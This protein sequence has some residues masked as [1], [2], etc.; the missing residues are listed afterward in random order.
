MACDWSCNGNWLASG[1]RDQLV[2]M[3]DIRVMKEFATFHGHNNQVG[4][5]WFVVCGRFL[6]HKNCVSVFRLLLWL[7]IR[8]KKLV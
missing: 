6:L 2:K 1:A 3:F 4:T 8:I 5:T 7:G